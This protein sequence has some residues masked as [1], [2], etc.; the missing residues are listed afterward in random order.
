LV[1]S[2]SSRE[3]EVLSPVDAL[4][5]VVSTWRKPQRYRGSVL[6]ERNG[7]QEAPVEL[8]AVRA[9]CI[10]LLRR[11]AA[12]YESV[13]TSSSALAANDQDVSS[14]RRPFALQVNQFAPG[15]EN[16]VVST[17]LRD[18][19]IDLDSEPRSGKLNGQLGD[20]SFLVRCHARQPSDRIGWAVSV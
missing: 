3:V 9:N 4:H 13:C 16:H 17:A 6:D 7:D 14:P 1:L 8:E 11:V 18:G 12:A 2:K 5:L 20:R 19:A 15:R 10:D